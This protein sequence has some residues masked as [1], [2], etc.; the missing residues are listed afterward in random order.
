VQTPP[1]RHRW[2]EFNSQPHDGLPEVLHS[3]KHWGVQRNLN[4]MPPENAARAIVRA[5]AAPIEES[6][7]TVVEV[8]FG[9]RTK[10]YAK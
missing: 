6:Y 9:G 1:H 7:T 10:E 8:Q 5:I 2:S 4:A 3:W